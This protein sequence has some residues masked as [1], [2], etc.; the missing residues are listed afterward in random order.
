MPPEAQEKAVNAPQLELRGLDRVPEWFSC[1]LESNGLQ[2]TLAHLVGLD[3]DQ[4]RLAGV[5]ALG[6]LLTLSPLLS[7]PPDEEG[8]I[9]EAVE[10]T[11]V[12]TIPAPRIVVYT[13]RETG[14][15]ADGV[16]YDMINAGTKRQLWPARKGEL[17]A[18][19]AQH[20][21]LWLA[22]DTGDAHC[23]WKTW[24]L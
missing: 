12:F 17:R 22:S 2:H 6:A 4:S 16:L 8:E 7:R 15:D 5:N 23:L 13:L 19:R 9:D 24:A 11:Y 14:T 1:F 10:P 20:L 18:A 21:A 3:G